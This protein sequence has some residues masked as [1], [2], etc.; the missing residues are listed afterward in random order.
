LD[1]PNA[2]SWRR[3]WEGDPAMDTYTAFY[4]MPVRVCVENCP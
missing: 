4:E 3:R 2:F 1:P